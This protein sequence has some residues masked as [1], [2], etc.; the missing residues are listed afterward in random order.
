[1]SGKGERGGWRGEVTCEHQ[2]SRW[3][4]KPG[5]G[6][7]VEEGVSVARRRLAAWWVA[8]EEGKAGVGGGGGGRRGGREVRGEYDEKV[9][10]APR[11][12]AEGKGKRGVGGATAMSVEANTTM[13]WGASGA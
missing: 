8:D 6:L 12:Q 2:R 9:V 10:L 3:K 7:E 5:V 13:R 4:C 1:M 11:A